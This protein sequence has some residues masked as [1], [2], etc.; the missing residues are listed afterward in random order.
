MS[1]EGSALCV[2]GA[3]LLVSLRARVL[4]GELA[5]TCSITV[6]S[7]TQSLGWEHYEVHAPEP[8]VVRR[9]P[10]PSSPSP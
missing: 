4:Q 1:G 3:S 2:A 10:P 6:C 7:Q 9:R 8:H 5:L